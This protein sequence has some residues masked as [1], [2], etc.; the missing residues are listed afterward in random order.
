MHELGLTLSR[1]QIKQ[2]EGQSGVSVEGIKDNGSTY[3]EFKG[4][5]V[6]SGLGGRLGEQAGR[7]HG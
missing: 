4:S 7:L 1:F 6:G 2:R 5:G 3:V